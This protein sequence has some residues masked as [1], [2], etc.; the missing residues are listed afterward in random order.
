M[1]GVRF[2]WY[3][4]RVKT[5]TRCGLEKPEDA[6][7]SHGAGHYDCFCRACMNAA[8]REKYQASPAYAERLKVSAARYRREHPEHIKAQKKEWSQTHR[9]DVRDA[10]VK[11]REL[12]PDHA[13][14]RTVVQRA[15]RSGA[16]IPRPCV[17]CGAEPTQA[18][19]H[20]GYAPEHQL[21]VVW[22]CTPHHRAL[23]RKY[24]AKIEKP[25]TE[26]WRDKPRFTDD[27]LLDRMRERAR[28]LGRTPIA[29]DMT[30][31]TTYSA[32]FGSWTAAVRAAG[33][34]DAGRRC[35]KRP[36]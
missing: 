36:T 4:E 1:N 22:L 11:S 5:C 10:V 31:N 27:E 18:H 9:Q 28:D 30:N 7:G 26:E 2:I 16:L 17:V 35:A 32:R 8:R 13:R 6:F 3:N 15:I 20:H 21:D 19:H 34:P 25:I 24:P 29:Q 23:H 12:H 33:L 14:A